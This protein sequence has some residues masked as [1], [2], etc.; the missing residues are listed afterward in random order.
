MGT[1]VYDL[2]KKCNLGSP[3]TIYLLASTAT[4]LFGH[5][6]TTPGHE[7][8]VAKGLFQATDHLSS[9]L[10]N[11]SCRKDTWNTP[12]EIAQ[13]TQVPRNGKA[14]AL[15]LCSRRHSKLQHST[16]DGERQRAGTGTQIEGS[17]I[18]GECMSFISKLPRDLAL[19]SVWPKIIAGHLSCKEK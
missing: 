17:V 5:D 11:C 12:S 2:I 13:G 16:A 8:T 14:D 9:F 7:E 15:H 6:R 18:D 19:I 10:K 4:V 1:H 3:Y